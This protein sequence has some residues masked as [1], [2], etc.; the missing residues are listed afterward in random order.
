MQSS[1][2]RLRISRESQLVFFAQFRHAGQRWERFLK[3][4]PLTHTGNRGCK[5]VHVLGP[6][7]MSVPAGHWR[8]AHLNA[9]R[10]DAAH[11]NVL[12]VTSTVSEDVVRDALKR[13]PEVSATQWLSNWLDFRGPPQFPLVPLGRPLPSLGPVPYSLHS[14]RSQ[15]I[16]FPVIVPTNSILTGGSHHRRRQWM[17][18]R[19]LS[20]K[21]RPP[22]ADMKKPLDVRGLEWRP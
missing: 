4:C 19:E 14:L 5:V 9:I 6:A 10:G 18:V 20:K 12:G 3:N 17:L 22:I 15:T 7:F 11:P 2:R 1:P 8:Y 13:V 21:S 16:L